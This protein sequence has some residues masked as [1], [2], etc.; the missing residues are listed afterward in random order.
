MPTITGSVVFVELNRAVSESLSDQEIADIV[1]LAE[2]TFG[3]NPGNVEA[4]INYDI[5][6][7][8]KVTTD[9]D[10]SE[11]DLA[12]ALQDSIADALN[13]HSS[14]VAVSIDPDTGIATYTIS[15]STAEDATALQ[16]ALQA[17]STNDA[18]TTGV[19]K[20]L[21][22]VTDVPVFSSLLL[23]LLL[24]FCL[25]LS[26]LLIQNIESTQR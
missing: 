7:T 10:V 14:D 18:I 26:S 13:I 21:P 6:G 23:L 20:V 1:A 22:A 4:D 24:L 25:S 9:D 15:S 2:S 8:I 3:V 16:E 5:T 19:S 12:S 11:E 17:S